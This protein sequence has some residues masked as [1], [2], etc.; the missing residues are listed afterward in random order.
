MA[1]RAAAGGL[2]ARVDGAVAVVEAVVLAGVPVAVGPREA[3]GAS[4]GGSAWEGSRG[5]EEGDSQSPA[6]SS[7]RQDETSK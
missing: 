4:A 5:G 7:L 2:I 3:L 6:L 1:R